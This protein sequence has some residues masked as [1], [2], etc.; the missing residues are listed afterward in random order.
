MSDIGPCQCCT[1]RSA[2]K[3]TYLH[4][5]SAALARLDVPQKRRPGGS[6]RGQRRNFRGSLQVV[7]SLNPEFLGVDAVLMHEVLYS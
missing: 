6:P 5:K 1:S 2:P 4:F 3:G 7:L